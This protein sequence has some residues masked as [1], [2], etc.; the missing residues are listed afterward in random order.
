VFT[1]K[2]VDVSDGAI[3]ASY[4]YRS[5]LAK[6]LPRPYSAAL[7]LPGYKIHTTSYDWLKRD[8]IDEARSQVISEIFNEIGNTLV[9]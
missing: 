9:K 5:E 1:A 4:Q 3:L 8:W 6:A 2:L 7:V